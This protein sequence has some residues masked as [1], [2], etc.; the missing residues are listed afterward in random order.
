MDH[1]VSVS[2]NSGFKIFLFVLPH[3]RENLCGRRVEVF[4]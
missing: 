4:E 3:A 2:D 1:S